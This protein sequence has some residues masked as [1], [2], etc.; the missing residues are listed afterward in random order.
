MG[1]P[2]EA[3]DALTKYLEEDPK[4]ADRTTV[5][6]RIANLKKR[7][8]T[9]PVPQR[10]RARP[11][12]P[13]RRPS[14]QPLPRAAPREQPTEPHSGLRRL[15]RRRSRCDRRRRD[16]RRGQRQFNTAEKTCKPTCSDSEVNSI[17]SMALVSDI[18]TGVAVVGV[19]VGAVLFFTAKGDTGEPTQ[20]TRP[21]IRAGVGP[22]GGNL[23]MTW[24]F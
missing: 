10:A 16:R 14:L 13:A 17:K 23:E 2:R 12:C 11:R 24:H 15:R 5:E 22:A 20:A 4:T 7:A 1:K 9:T 19:G 3:V 18:L 6:T 8:D 21:S